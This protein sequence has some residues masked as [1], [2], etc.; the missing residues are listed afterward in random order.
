MKLCM[1]ALSDAGCMIMRNNC[2]VLKNEAGIPVKFGVGNPGGSDLIGITPNGKFLA[3]EVKTPTGRVRPDQQ[4]FIDAVKKHGGLAGIA[5]SPQ[6][7]ISI[8]KGE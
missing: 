7:A 8:I 3:V 1:I 6:D 4:R 2:G 5:R